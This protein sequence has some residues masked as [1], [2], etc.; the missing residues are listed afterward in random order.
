MRL[1]S[2]IVPNAIIPSLA[3]TAAAVSPKDGPAVAAVK[4]QVVQELV[5][6]L[7]A[8]NAFGPENTDDVVSEVLRREQLGTTGIG[9]H[10]AIP[11][12]RHAAAKDLIGAL[13]LSPGGL[14]FDSLDGEPVYVFVLLVSPK[15]RP[16][17]HLRALEAVV[18]TM[19]NEEFVRQ[20]RGCGTKDEVWKLL[21]SLPGL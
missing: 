19:R 20:L 9:R 3:T 5:A 1:T 16:G 11:H 12:S 13:G 7:Q 4:K 15:D 6:A 8:A 21:E 18:R 17:E 2:F 10:I 14:P